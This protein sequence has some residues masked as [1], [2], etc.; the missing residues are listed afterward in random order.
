MLAGQGPTC[1]KPL[2]LCP[3][4][5]VQNWGKVRDAPRQACQRQPVHLT[6]IGC[7]HTR[8]PFACMHVTH[9]H[10]PLPPPRRPQEFERWLGD[11]VQPV[12]V[13]DTRAAAVKNALQD[14]RGFARPGAKPRVLVMSYTTYRRALAWRGAWCGQACA[15]PPPPPAAARRASPRP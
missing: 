4:S 11:R 14:F 10:P 15:V 6:C 7:L 9:T 3:S 13:D 2:I 8:R 5:L 1:K 12:V